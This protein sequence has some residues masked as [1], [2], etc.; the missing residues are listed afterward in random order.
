MSHPNTVEAHLFARVQTVHQPAEKLQ[1]LAEVARRQLPGSR[2]LQGFRD[3]YFLVDSKNGKA[4]VISLWDT[5]GD[6]RRVVADAPARQRTE[7]E[8]GITSPA[9]EVFEVALQTS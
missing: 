8:A 2:K 4:L 7:A 9:T 6:L 1:E 3:F 5:E